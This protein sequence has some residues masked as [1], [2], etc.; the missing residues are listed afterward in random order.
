MHRLAV[1]ITRE[2]D[3]KCG[4]VLPACNHLPDVNAVYI[5][6]N[7][8]NHNHHYCERVPVRLW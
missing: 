4:P 3:I 6:H 7:A 2:L 8:R 1:R 5:G